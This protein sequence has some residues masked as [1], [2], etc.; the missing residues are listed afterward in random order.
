MLRRTIIKKAKLES[1]KFF[2]KQQKLDKESIIYKSC[3]NILRT[4]NFLINYNNPLR[5]LNNIEFIYDP[6]SKH[7]A[8]TDGI[9]IWINTYKKYTL[10]ILINTLIHEGLHYTIYRDSIYDIPEEKEHNIMELINPRLIK[11]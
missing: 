4:N 3:R 8:E 1:K 9:N 11:V 10:E 5:C 6:V 7:W 2:I